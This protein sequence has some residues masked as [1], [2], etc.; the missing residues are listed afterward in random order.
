MANKI[1]CKKN[2]SFTEIIFG[3]LSCN[4]VLTVIVCTGRAL[5]TNLL[6]NNYDIYIVMTQQRDKK[7]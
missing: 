3:L 6:N 5:W 1:V 2:I 4:L 7:I